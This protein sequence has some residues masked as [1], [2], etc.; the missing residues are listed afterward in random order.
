MA[1]QKTERDRAMVVAQGQALILL[2][3]ALQALCVMKVEEFVS[4]F[5]VLAVVVA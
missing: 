1:V 3:S 5:G 4:T 2:T